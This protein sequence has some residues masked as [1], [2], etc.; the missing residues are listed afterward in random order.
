VQ[1]KG[2]GLTGRVVV[3]GQALVKDGSPIAIAHE[4]DKADTR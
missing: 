3:L 1:V 2:E 4:S